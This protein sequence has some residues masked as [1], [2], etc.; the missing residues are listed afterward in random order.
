VVAFST[1]G[2]VLV[3]EVA[4]RIAAAVR[5]TAARLALS[6]S[7]N[8]AAHFEYERGL[9]VGKDL[10][11]GGWHRVIE[12][13]TRARELDPSF[14]AAEVLLSDTYN[15]LGMLSLMKPNVAFQKAREA[16]ERALQLAPNAAPGHAALALS[17]FG[18]DWD[19]DVA[20]EE[21]RRSIWI[22]TATHACYSWL[23]AMLG[24]DRRR[25]PKR[26]TPRAR[27]V[28][29][30]CRPAPC[31]PCHGS[32][33]RG[34][35]RTDQRCLE[36]D[37][38]HL[39]AVLVRASACTFETLRRRTAIWAGWRNS[40][41]APH[42]LGLLGKSYG[43]AGRYDESARDRDGARSARPHHRRPALLRLRAAR[44]RR[45]RTRSNSGTGLWT[46]LRRSITSR[47]SSGSCSRLTRGTAIGCGRCGST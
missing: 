14:A 20:E 6:T 32:P 34:G 45:T 44:A 29:A 40:A 38:S 19:W 13:A 41:S 35:A 36:R 39:Y 9:H 12:H 42:Y 1:T 22:P 43:E 28:R 17:R 3:G 30:S 21:F 26:I 11:R 47:P 5:A 18:G 27:R 25:S 15:F 31:S 16:A 8:P 24:R 37:P 10:F 7:S 2:E 33:L 46:A 4:T 23:L